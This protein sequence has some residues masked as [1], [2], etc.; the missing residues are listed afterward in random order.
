[1]EV[2]TLYLKYF[3]FVNFG[4]LAAV[5]I[6]I[7]SRIDARGQDSNKVSYLRDVML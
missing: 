6:R 1:M 5:K 2:I 4:R 3:V 7:D